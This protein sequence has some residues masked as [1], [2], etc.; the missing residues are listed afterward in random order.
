[1]A[2]LSANFQKGLYSL[3]DSSLD[4]VLFLFLFLVIFCSLCFSYTSLLLIRQF[5]SVAS[6]IKPPFLPLIISPMPG[7]Y[8]WIFP[9]WFCFCVSNSLPIK[10]DSNFGSISVFLNLIFS[11]QCSIFTLAF[12]FQNVC[13]FS[14]YFCTVLHLK[15]SVI[16]RKK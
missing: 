14:L 2:F 5:G 16:K 9:S 7:S 12:F 8:N 13:I 1:M 6:L 10:P 15:T 3:P 4:R 11:S